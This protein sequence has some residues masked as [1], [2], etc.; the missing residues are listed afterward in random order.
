MTCPGCQ[1]EV[2]RLDEK[3]CETCVST[4]ER[5]AVPPG[6]V[7]DGGTG[8]PLEAAPLHLEDWRTKRTRDRERYI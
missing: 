5:G 8:L 7:S 2:L 4:I 6:A 3:L 1:Q